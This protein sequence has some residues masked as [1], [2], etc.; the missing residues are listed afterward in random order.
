MRYIQFDD[1]IHKKY[2]VTF[3]TFNTGEIRTWDYIVSVKN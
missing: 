2:T 3:I 1:I